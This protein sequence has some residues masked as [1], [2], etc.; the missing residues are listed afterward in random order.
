VSSLPDFNGQAGGRAAASFTGYTSPLIL[1]GFYCAMAEA[2][3][4]QI[5]SPRKISI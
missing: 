1:S 4:T 2:V 5:A 3:S